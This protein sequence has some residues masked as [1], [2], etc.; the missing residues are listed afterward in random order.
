[1]DGDILCTKKRTL[2]WF[3]LRAIAFASALGLL[4]H[5]MRT[6]AISPSRMPRT[7]IRAHT[8]ASDQPPIPSA[9]RVLG[10]TY[11]ELGRLFGIATMTVDAWAIGRKPIPL[12][13]HLAMLFLVGRL[14][15]IVGKYPPN[16]RH[17]KRHQVAIDAA[18]RWAALARDEL[19]EDEGGTYEAAAIEREERWD[20]V[21]SLQEQQRLAFARLIVH[22][23]RWVLLDDAMGALDAE[24]RRLVLSIFERD[25]AGAAVLS[26]DRSRANHGFYTRALQ[27]VRLPGPCLRTRPR[28]R[29]WASAASVVVCSTGAE[30]VHVRTH[31]TETV[32]PTV[33]TCAAGQGNER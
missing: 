28:P 20:K 4:L 33:E 32:T 25:L 2:F 21:L 18:K 16:S 19:D 3:H 29:R 5:V 15:G 30:P 10:F 24:H 31:P 1:M 22:A 7:H 6:D 8:R 14:T 23:P 13:R 12:H 9:L 27:V 17:A 26:V 11:A